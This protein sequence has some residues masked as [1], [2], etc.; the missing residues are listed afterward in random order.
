MECSSSIVECLKTNKI[1]PVPTASYGKNPSKALV[2]D[3]DFF[4]GK[5]WKID[6]TGAVSLNKYQI[7][8]GD[9]CCFVKEWTAYVSNDDTNWIEVDYQ[10]GYPVGRNFTIKPVKARFFKIAGTSEG[11]DF[12]RFYWIKFYGSIRPL[13]NKNMISYNQNMIFCSCLIFLVFLAASI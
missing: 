2:Y 6:F 5:E 11:D 12:L 3:Q 8:T 13:Y 1:N 9:W 4:S 7:S 10:A